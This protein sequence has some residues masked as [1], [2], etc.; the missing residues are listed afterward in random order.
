LSDSEDKPKAS[1]DERAAKVREKIASGAT[2]AAV[3]DELK[4]SVSTV[5]NDLKR[6]PAAIQKAEAPKAPTVAAPVERLKKAASTVVE[7]TRKAVHVSTIPEERLELRKRQLEMICMRLRGEQIPRNMRGSM[8]ALTSEKSIRQ[9]RA[10]VQSADI[11]LDDAL[12]VERVVW[13]HI[14]TEEAAHGRRA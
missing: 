9:I 6:E 4:V 3:A 5:R 14:E 7:K 13:G 8:T 10:I 12:K 2:Q 1:K 11:E